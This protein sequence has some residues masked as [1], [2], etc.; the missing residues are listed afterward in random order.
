MTAL[1]DGSEKIQ[2]VANQHKLM[3]LVATLARMSVGFL[4]FVLLARYL[5]PD[6]FGLI[7]TAMAY[8]TFIGVVTDFGLATAAL[9][10]ACAAPDNIRSVMGNAL[11]VKGLL[12]APIV[13]VGGFTLSLFITFDRL[14]VYLLVFIG[15]LSFSFGEIS[16]VAARANRQF[17][18]EAAIV[19]AASV[20]MLV[21]MGGV[22]AATGKVVPV[23]V[24]F[25]VT[26]VGY[27]LI[28][29]F[30]LR[31]WLGNP[32][33]RTFS[34]LIS[35][36]RQASSYAAD[37]FLTNLA[38]QVDMLL[39]G[40]VLSL[41]DMGI[42]QSGARLVQVI[43]PFAVVLSTVYLPN[44]TAAHAQGR[45]A[46]FQRDAVRLT[47][48]FTWLAVL[49]GLAFAFFGPKITNLLYSSAY[50][51]L[52]PLWTGFAIFA[53]LRFTA[54]AYGV[55]LVALGRIAPR[56]VA[57]LSSIALLAIASVTVLGRGGL[58][59][60]AWLLAGSAV[61]TFL[62]LGLSLTRTGANNRY[63]VG[64]MA[65]ALT[66]VAGIAYSQAWK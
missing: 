63:I 35:T 5:Q 44:L 58:P 6:A 33:V 15:A 29:L 34:D 62:L 20:A 3:M 36:A 13:L 9:R 24:A 52:E 37:S 65:T 18:L 56:L 21:L 27:L 41:H 14:I 11:A 22:A 23:A 31:I 50:K 43:L 40:M 28:V 8:A 66:A 59:V 26:R 30:A 61:P 54:A 48:E 53:V 49:G 42:Y 10:D 32:F 60:A 19:L 47:W 17:A 12:A 16:L 2:R 55:Q 38:T 1:K 25:A 57:Q 7:A 51:P 4:T 45:E 46:D 39:F 64:S